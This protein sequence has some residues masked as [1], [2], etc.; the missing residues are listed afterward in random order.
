MEDWV[1]QIADD[2]KAQE[3][4][5]FVLVEGKKVTVAELRKIFDSICNEENWKLP[6]AAKVHHSMVGKVLAAAEFFLADKGEVVGIEPI[7]GRVILEGK[8]YQAW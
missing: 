6:W 1:K 4:K 2:I 5:D 7:T 8:G 3:E